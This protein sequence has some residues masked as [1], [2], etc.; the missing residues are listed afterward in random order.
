M[1]RRAVLAASVLLSLAAC[2]SEPDPPQTHTG[3]CSH[4]NGHRRAFQDVPNCLM[5]TRHR[6]INGLEPIDPEQQ[7]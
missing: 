4:Y 2:A 1:S 5:R 3:R 6:M 7:S